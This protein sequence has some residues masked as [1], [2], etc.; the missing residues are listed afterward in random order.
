M[1]DRGD[2]VEHP[3]F[4]IQGLFQVPLW[5]AQG[6]STPGFAVAADQHRC[7][8]IQ[9]HHFGVYTHLLDL[10]Q[11]FREVFQFRGEI[12]GIHPYRGLHRLAV[13]GGF[14]LLDQGGQQ[15][16]GQIV[17]T[18]KT[19]ILQDVQCGAFSGAGTAADD[20]QS[21]SRCT[22]SH[23][24]PLWVAASNRASSPSASRSFPL[25]ASLSR[26]AAIADRAWR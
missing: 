23:G 13:V 9:E 24:S 17:D 21:K 6:M 10:F 22:L 1:R 20:N 4:E 19:Q 8:G 25:P 26:S 12:A 14:Q 5:R 2:R 3:A 16:G 18:G 11:D 15:G 7:A